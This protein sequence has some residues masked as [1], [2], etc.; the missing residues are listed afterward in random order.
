MR[1]RCGREVAAA[2]R[3]RI[4]DPR[5]DLTGIVN[6][7]IVDAV[8]GNVALLRQSATQLRSD[9]LA[10]RFRTHGPRVTEDSACAPVLRPVVFLLST[11]SP[12]PLPRPPSPTVISS[13]G[14]SRMRVCACR[15]VWRYRLSR[16]QRTV[17]CSER[18]IAGVHAGRVCVRVCVC[19]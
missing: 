9:P 15:A 8:A 10:A 12:P 13:R 16:Q 18:T 1:R 3:T 4:H 11:S 17:W 6:V 14:L 7:A 19:V 5:G 2:L